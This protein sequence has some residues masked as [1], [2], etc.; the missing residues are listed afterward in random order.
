MHKLT[1]HVQGSFPIEWSRTPLRVGVLALFVGLSLT[2]TVVAQPPPSLNAARQLET[3]LVDVIAR[4]EKSIVSI[5]RSVRI[6][7]DDIPIEARP[8]ERRGIIGLETTAD[9]VP[10]DFGSG[11]IIA[12]QDKPGSTERFVLTNSHVVLGSRR[13]GDWRPPAGAVREAPTI[14]V[15]LAS[16]HTVS[17]TLIAADPRSDLAILKLNLP[18]QRVPITA[19]PPL[20]FAVGVEPKK[21]QFVIALGNP[22]AIARDG[23]ASV[24]TGIIS[25]ISRKP[26]P[27]GQNLD[28]PIVEEITVHHF[29]TLLQVDTRLNLGTSG[30]ALVNLDGQLIGLTTSLAALQGYEKSA[31]FAIPMDANVQRIIRSLLEGYEVEYG[32]LGIRPGLA[33]PEMLDQ[34]RDLTSQATAARAL[35]VARYSPADRAGMKD[36]DLILA[37]NDEPVYTD[38][39]LIRAV[40]LLGPDVDARLQV[41]RPV[42]RSTV[43]LTVRL[44]KW[45]VYDDS[46]IYATQSRYPPWRGIRCDYATARRKY[47]PSNALEEMRRGVVVTSVE[48]GSPAAAAGLVEGV[49]V[50][51]IDNTPVQSPKDLMQAAESREQQPVIL[52]LD[53]GQSLRVAPGPPR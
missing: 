25:N 27:P 28:D 45:P 30:G 20:S 37:V 11:V 8:L 47:L 44:G 46:L 31:G 36:G 23:S 19:A 40:G 13:Q 50:T 51:A 33:S 49:F 53:D 6:P 1:I 39:D 29:G 14:Y 10:T 48:P 9:F 12:R 41:L 24:S 2:Q 7:I 4:T 35:R 18:E 22:Y 32:F 3:E 5:A 42:A 38:I 34:Y 26:E 17:A 16:R 52:H 15:R 43:E 21:G